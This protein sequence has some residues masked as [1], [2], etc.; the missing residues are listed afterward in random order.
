MSKINLRRFVDINLQPHVYTN[1]TGTR[2][3]LALFTPDTSESLTTEF[4]SLKEV[5]YSK[6]SS[7]YKYL[8]IF[9]NNGG[10]KVKVYE[11][12]S[13]NQIT[14]DTIKSLPIE[15][16]Y[17]GCVTDLS[18]L[19]DCYSVLK[20]LSQS[21]NS[22]STIYG[23]NEKIILA[24]TK[25]TELDEDSVKNF[26]VKYSTVLGSEM[27]IAAYL[28][29]INIDETDSVKDYAFT[30]EN[31]TPEDIG[32]ELFGNLQTN[33]YNI[34]VNLTGTI[35]NCG[36]NCKDGADLVNNFLRIILQQ[37][38]TNKLIELLAQKI[39]STTGIS[40][41]YAVLSQELE[42]YKN[43]GYLTTDKIWTDRDLKEIIEGVEYTI[44]RKGD[45]LNNGYLIKILPMSALTPEERM[46]HKAPPIRIVIADQYSIRMITIKGDVI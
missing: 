31:I 11:G 10:V 40:K 37:T 34:D 4:T 24:A 13:Y 14:K 1:S 16:I 35:R 28:S 23:I 29:Q 20:T 5:P 8:E 32:D 3:T 7:T 43:C 2:N 17:V 44:I 30:Q 6:E 18:N 26:V 19:D 9:F 42:R 12:V 22:D 25:S 15:Q 39:K 38:C 36:G 46:A 41:M 27:T 33:N 45:A 21:L